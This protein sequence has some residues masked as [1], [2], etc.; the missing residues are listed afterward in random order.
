MELLASS[1]TLTIALLGLTNSL[2]SLLIVDATLILIGQSLVGIRN[3][4]ELF[5]G[6]L[7][8]VLVLVGVVLDGEL[9]ER[10][11]YLLF[12]RVSLHAQELVV[13]LT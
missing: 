12:G 11:L 10:L 7:G 5:L 4:L 9:F 1:A 8:V 3:L 2:F 13:V 6:S